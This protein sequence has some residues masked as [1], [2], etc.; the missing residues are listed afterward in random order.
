MLASGSVASTA[1]ASVS[2]W[3][4]GA[5]SSAAGVEPSSATAALGSSP[6]Q[7]KYVDFLHKYTIGCQPSTTT[8]LHI[9]LGK[10]VHLQ[11]RP[12][13]SH[14]RGAKYVGD[15]D[16]SICSMR[17]FFGFSSH[18]LFSNRV[19][20]GSVLPSTTGACGSTTVVD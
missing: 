19:V 14:G 4:R 15:V 7:D 17:L 3:G 13:N 16:K 5:D 20:V 1:S 2:A 6:S 12:D 11:A 8:N 10:D 18:W 9:L